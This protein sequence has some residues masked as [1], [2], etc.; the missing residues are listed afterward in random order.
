MISGIHHVKLPVSDVARS[1]AWYHRVLGFE[2]LV[3]FEEDGVVAGVALQRDGCQPHLALRH[4]PDRARAL[5]GFNVVALL[6][7]SRDDVQR[8]SARLDDLGEPHGGLVRGHDGGAVLI[9]L[10]DPDG[11]EIRLYA[12]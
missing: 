6:V 2:T 11:I 7:P 12:N 10:H 9:G 5:S 8:W 3:E 4:D 1:Q